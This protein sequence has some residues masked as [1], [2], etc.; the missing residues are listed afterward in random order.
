MRFQKGLLAFFGVVVL[1]TSCS[2]A[3]FD[4]SKLVVGLECDYA[5]FN[6]TTTSSTDTTLPINGVAGQF[7]DGYDIQVAKFIGANLGIDVV[8]KKLAWGALIP[9]IQSGDINAIIAGMSYTE[10][11]DQSVDFTDAYYISDIVAVVQADSALASFTS[12]QE[13]SG[14]KVIS[15]LGT[16]QDSIIDQIVGVVHQ[17][18][19]ETFNTAA[20]SVI[21][22]DSDALIA[23]YPVARAIVNANPTLA[24]VQFTVGFTGID[25]NALSV[26]VAVGEGNTELQDRINLALAT[27]TSGE[28]LSM[29]DG[30]IARSAIE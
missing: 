24:V 23:E 4:N 11:R 6:W 17:T 25:E 2:A 3:K 19:S 13:L 15:Q 21:S 20:L 9:A 7:A 8:I 26:A 28:R 12:I 27:L 30:A 18:G 29:M 14:Y 22:G 10:E 5:P 1:A 16:V